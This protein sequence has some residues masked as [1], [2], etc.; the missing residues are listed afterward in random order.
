MDDIYFSI[1]KD[2]EGIYKDKGSKFIGIAKQFS[3]EENLKSILDAIKKEHS[4]AR[5]FCYAYRLGINGEIFRANDDGEPAG[6][7]GKPIL[8]TLLSAQITNVLVVVVRYFGGTLL[9]VPGLINAYKEAS[10]AALANAEKKVCIAEDI[11]NITFDYV[12]LNAV[13]KII[14]EAKI[15]IGKQI[16]D[17]M[18]AFELIIR[19]Q[20]KDEILLKLNKHCLQIQYIKTL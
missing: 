11:Y 2:A 20:L 16:I 10:F 14:K 9:G 17:Q 15:Q 1:A 4:T 3:Q 18:C 19:K 6:S 5:H 13:M 12:N 8:N 7:A